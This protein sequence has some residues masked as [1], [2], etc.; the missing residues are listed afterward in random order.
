[1]HDLTTGLGSTNGYDLF[2]HGLQLPEDM[3]EY[4]AKILQRLRA[5]AGPSTQLV[6][7]D[8]IMNYASGDPQTVQDIPGANVP[9]PPAPL[10]A[11]YGVA[12]AF[13]NL[14]DI[15]VSQTRIVPYNSSD[16]LS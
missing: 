1:M 11:N 14:C 9:A 16:A 5:A 2:P 12:T 3:A 4:A 13:S 6:V 8:C 15:Q 10:L 7:V